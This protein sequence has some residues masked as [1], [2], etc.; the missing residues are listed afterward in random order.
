MRDAQAPATRL[1]V[2]SHNTGKVREIARAAGAIRR[3]DGLG[4]GARTAGARGDG[5]DASPRMP[6]SRR[7][8]AAT[9][10]G[11]LA[12]ADDFGA[13]GGGAWAAR[14][15]FIPRAGPGRRRI[16]IWPWPGRGRDAKAERPRRS[17]ANFTCALAL[18]GPAARPRSFEGKVY[19]KIVWPPRGTRGFGYDPIFV[20]DGHSADLRRDGARCEACDLA[21]RP[22]FR[23]IMPAPVS[24]I[25]D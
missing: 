8:A 13:R 14:P 1:V 16:S 20:A 3:R 11:M 18:A 5:H 2:A 21:P 23:E 25:G 24:A 7:D 22:R 4:G 10:S 12:L 6:S 15:A 19:G 17:T 9:A